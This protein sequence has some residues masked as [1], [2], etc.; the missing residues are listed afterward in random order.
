[1]GC[2]YYECSISL[3]LESPF[4]SAGLAAPAFGLDVTQLRDV[5]GRPIF[6]A[7]QIRGV[8]RNALQVLSDHGYAG[9]VPVLGMFGDK[10]KEDSGE[11]EPGRMR[12]RDLRA[13]EPEEPQSNTRIRINE[14]TGAVEQGH[15]LVTEIAWP[16]GKHVDFAGKVAFFAASGDDAKT[17]RTVLEK[18][19]K[20]VQ[21]IGAFKTSG[22]GRIESARLASRNY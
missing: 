6:P 15:L 18:A 1:M 2:G 4:L 5:S 17:I 9:A 10:D 16:I 21:S 11:G 22:F 13:T 7:G 19:L 14:T 8:I 12:F 20:L 3:K